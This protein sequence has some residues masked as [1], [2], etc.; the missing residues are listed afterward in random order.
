MIWQR[1]GIFVLGVLAGSM[2]NRF[3][4]WWPNH[5]VYGEFRS[6]C[7]HCG[8][9]WY[10]LEQVSLWGRLFSEGRC[11]YCGDK[12]PLR[13]SLVELATGVLVLLVSFRGK[14]TLDFVRLFLFVLLVVPLFFIDLKHHR[15]PNILTMP[16]IGL[17]LI[18]SA[19]LG[20][21]KSALS[22]VVV[23]GGVLFVVALV[24]RGGIGMGDAKLQAMVGAF[25]GLRHML[26]SL[27]IGVLLGGI[28][29]LL[30]L[31]FQVRGRKDMIPYGPFL[32]TGAILTLLVVS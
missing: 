5:G 13:H 17:G 22:G 26:T 16:G 25:L 1:I 30:L 20:Y 28:V 31:V 3:I 2:L 24:T 23:G 32:I 19:A 21:M 9:P 14:G 18:L 8:H 4:S 10:G 7:P 11:Q 6:T 12:V 27:A 29:G 15:L